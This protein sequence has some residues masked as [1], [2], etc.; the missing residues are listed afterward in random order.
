MKTVARAL[1]EVG[2]PATAGGAKGGVVEAAPI[3]AGKRRSGLTRAT[4]TGMT[5][6][7]I[8]DVLIKFARQ[9]SLSCFT[10]AATILR[11]SEPWLFLLR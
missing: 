1:R 9:N 2:C 7:Q 3:V 6:P 4:A 10:A 11:Q 5:L 8:R